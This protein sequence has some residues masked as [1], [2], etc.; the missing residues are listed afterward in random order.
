MPWILQNTYDAYRYTGD[1][2]YLKSDIYPALREEAQLYAQ[3]L[4]RDSDGKYVT[5][6]TYSPEHGPRTAG[7]TYEQALIWQLFHDAI[8]AG[9]V[10]GED[11]EVLAVWQEKFDNLRTPIEIGS[12]GQIKEWYTEEAFNK[13]A[14]GN[15][16]GEGFGH[17][18]MSHMLGLF[19]GTLISADTPEWFA[20]ARVSMNLRTDES[21]GWGMGQRIN[22]WAHL[23]D[24]DRAYKLLG[25]QF[26]NGIYPNL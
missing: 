16:L 3:L 19:P 1:V 22:T 9:K 20:A 25:D 21:T 2:E 26:K 14:N 18:H 12:D 15:S 13:D 10:V 6:P 24:G 11:P 8:E 5:S 17:R 7:N 23:R 4:V